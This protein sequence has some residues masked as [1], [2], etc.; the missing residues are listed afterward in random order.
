MK[1]NTETESERGN[2]YVVAAVLGV[3]FLLGLAAVLNFWMA[4]KIFFEQKQAAEDGVESTYSWENAETN[5][6]WFKTQEQ[7]IKLKR[8]QANNTKTQIDRMEADY[9]ENVSE[10]PPDARDRYEELNQQLLAQ[11]NMHNQYVAEYNARSNMENRNLFKDDL[12]YEMEEKF[13]TGDGR[14]N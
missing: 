14:G 6:E 4:P 8:Q 13:W 2:L 7:D 1:R 11:Q 5:Y 3:V 12:P 9:G 10:W